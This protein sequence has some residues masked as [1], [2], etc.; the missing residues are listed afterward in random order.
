MSD[1]L[2]SVVVA[3]RNGERYLR[4]ALESVLAQEYEPLEVIV[5]DGHSDDATAAIATAFADVRWVLQQGTGIAGAYNQ[6]IATAAGALV[7][8]LSHDD[9]W[10]PDKLPVQ[11]G[12]MLAHPT[13]QYTTA[14]VRFFL[15]PGCAIPPG[16]R[17]ELLR[18]DHVGNIME[19]L[20][21]RR[22]VFDVVG[23]FDPKLRTAEDVDWFARAKDAGVPTAVIPRVLLQK[24][25]HDGNAS[26]NAP[27][28]DADLMSA[29]RRS[30]GRKRERS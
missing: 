14:R 20:V 26:L 11:V 21:A 6:G 17:P 18:G 19:T 3:V 16:F 4:A 5:V 29:L 24:R 13:V 27:Q 9:V 25:V 10:A 15:E 30:I 1:P 22:S 12:Y 7:A 28:N 8:F 23:T 2:V